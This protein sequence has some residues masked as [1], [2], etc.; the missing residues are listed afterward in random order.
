M[1]P[2]ARFDIVRSLARLGRGDEAYTVFAA[3]PSLRTAPAYGHTA[4]TV[5]SVTRDPA[6]RAELREPHRR[7]HPRRE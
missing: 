1:L 4:M 3:D 5:L 7:R 2:A 6:R